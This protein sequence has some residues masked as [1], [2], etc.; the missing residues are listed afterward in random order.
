M[1][2]TSALSGW[3]KHLKF[4]FSLAIQQGTVSKK[5]KKKLINE[6]HLIK[7]GPNQLFLG[8]NPGPVICQIFPET[9]DIWTYA[10]I[11]IFRC[12]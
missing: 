2:V 7:S 11:L 9:L 3:G 6:I 12:W 1:P 8:K 10:R 5:A 4:K